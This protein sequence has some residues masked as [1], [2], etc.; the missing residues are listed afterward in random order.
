MVTIV[1]N[2]V[3]NA[4]KFTEHGSVEVHIRLE[5]AAPDAAAAPSRLVFVVA[6]TGIGIPQDQL[7]VVFEM[8]RQIDGSDTRRH[9]GVGLGLY[10]VMR[11]TQ[12]LG[13][14][15]QVESV[16]GA[17]STFTVSV[18]VRAAGVEARARAAS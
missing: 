15:V 12:A 14:T 13:G 16:P 11:L 5:S 8:F 9:G 7:G 18:P 17:G 2:L 3:H 6:D 1:R 4:L 10:I